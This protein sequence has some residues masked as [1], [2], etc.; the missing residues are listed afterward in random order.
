LKR[1]T[2]PHGSVAG[3]F[4]FLRLAAQEGQVRENNLLAE[5]VIL[6]VM[7]VS[8]MRPYERKQLNCPV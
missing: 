2:L 5:M 3:F 1:E 7:L 6:I 4:G 8:Q